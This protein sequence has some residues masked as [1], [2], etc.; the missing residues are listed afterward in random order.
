[1]LLEDNLGDS[2]SDSPVFTLLLVDLGVL[3]DE[4]QKNSLYI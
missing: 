4:T 2:L 1:M 3:G